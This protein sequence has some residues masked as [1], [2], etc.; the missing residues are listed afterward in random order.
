M[1][2][3][4]PDDRLLVWGTIAVQIDVF[5]YD[6]YC[7]FAQKDKVQGFMQNDVILL[8]FDRDTLRRCPVRPNAPSGLVFGSCVTCRFVSTRRQKGPG[9]P[10]ITMLSVTFRSF[11]YFFTRLFLHT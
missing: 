1:H 7:S 6:K 4:K 10:D 5:L 11:A 9:H 8:T 3:Q 2:F